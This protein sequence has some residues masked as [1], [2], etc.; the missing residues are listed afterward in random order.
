MPT[1]ILGAVPHAVTTDDTYKGYFIP[2][3]AGVMN[4]TWAINMDPA[5]SKDPRTFDPNRCKLSDLDL[6]L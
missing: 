5:R 2:K 4:N 1:T 6:E 3:G